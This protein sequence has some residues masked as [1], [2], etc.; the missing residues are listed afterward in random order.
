M[1]KIKILS[2]N[3]NEK[4]MDS[5]ASLITVQTDLN[6]FE[7]FDSTYKSSAYS[8]TQQIHIQ[9]YIQTKCVHISIKIH[10]QKCL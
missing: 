3:E 8:I 9:V 1:D 10:V 7:N 6:I 2:V 5:P 4:Q